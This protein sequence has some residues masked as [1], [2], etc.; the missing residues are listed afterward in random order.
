MKK[1]ILLLLILT[2]LLCMSACNKDGFDWSDLGSV[3]TVPSL[4]EMSTISWPEGPAGQLLPVPKSTIGKFIYETANNFRVYIGNT[5]KEDYLEYI[6]S[7][8]KNGFNIDY[9]KG[10]DFYQA[11]N[12]ERWHVYLKYEAEN[13]MSITIYPPREENSTS[14]STG[15]TTSNTPTSGGSSSSSSSNDGLDP[16]F[17][18]AMD[19]YERFMGEY[20][21]FMKKY[22]ANPT[23]MSLL[24]SYADYMSKYSQ[25][26]SD[27]AKWENED[28][29]TAETAYYI[30]VQARVSKKLLEVA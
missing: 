12:S 6:K 13:V 11:Y 28:M 9:S 23:D 26:T 16:K 2:T 17:K 25:F 21:A 19:S 4:E 24:S 15:G 14:P 5:P 8:S 22:K 3:V 20:V 29:N 18:A 1:L 30:E 10:D 27:F 7:C